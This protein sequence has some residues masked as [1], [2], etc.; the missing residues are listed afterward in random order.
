MFPNSMVDNALNSKNTR[1]WQ[2]C[3]SLIQHELTLRIQIVGL[4]QIRYML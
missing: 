4:I 2:A 3:D 1:L